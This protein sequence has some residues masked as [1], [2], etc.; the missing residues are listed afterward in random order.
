[1]FIQQPKMAKVPFSDGVTLR[2]TSNVFAALI[3]GDM[4]KIV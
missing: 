2:E 3:V 1:M 4:L